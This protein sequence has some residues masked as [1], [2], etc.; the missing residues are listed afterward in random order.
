[1]SNLAAVFSMA[2]LPIGVSLF[3]VSIENY[4]NMAIFI[5]FLIGSIVFFSLSILLFRIAWNFQDMQDKQDRDNH[6]ELLTAI[7]ELGDKFD[8]KRG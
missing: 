2:C 5:G 3:I 1:M 7:R 8:I 4:K 6:K